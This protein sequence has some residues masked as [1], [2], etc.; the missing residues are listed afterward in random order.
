MNLQQMIE[1]A[2][3]D[4]MG[5]LDEA[6]QGQFEAAFRAAAP[7]VQA[8]VRREQTRLSVIDALLP[9]VEAPAGLRA[10]VLDAV[11]RQIVASGLS[12]SDSVAGVLPPMIQSRNVSRVWRAAAL[13]LAAAAVVMGVS[14]FEFYKHSNELQVEMAK[15]RD[16]EGLINRFGASYVRSVL[17]NKDTRRV[18]F[19]PAA[20]GSKGQVS[21]FMNPEWKEAKLFHSGL[22]DAE[23]RTYRL[24][25]VDEQNHVVSI[26]KSFN[27]SGGM[28][29]VTFVLEQPAPK[30]HLA[31]LTQNSAGTDEVVQTGELPAPTL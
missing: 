6:E 1:L 23:G 21:V 7:Q 13:G 9:E 24:A 27:P 3:L 28:D 22:G 19:S 8:Q 20:A 14:T 18:V 15:D 10:A 11:R 17:F 29:G 4:A 26:L 16:M 31:I 5:L 12:E 30:S 25:L 2:V